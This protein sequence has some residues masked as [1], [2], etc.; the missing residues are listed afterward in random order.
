MSTSQRTG[1]RTPVV[2][3]TGFLGAGKSTLVNQLLRDP[4]MTN[5]ALIINEFGDISIDDDLIRHQ[6]ETVVE[7][8]GGCVCCAMQATLSETLATLDAAAHDGIDRVLIETTGLANVGPV[9]H[10]IAAD[11]DLQRSHE[12]YAVATVVSAANGSTTLDRHPE[13]V[14]QLAVA[15]LIVVTKTDL[16]EDP[17]DLLDRIECLNPTAD[18]AIAP[19][20]K[21]PA[22]TVLDA[23]HAGLSNLERRA[24]SGR[25]DGRHDAH[26]VT[27]S[28][29]RDTPFA[30]ADLTGFW[31]SVAAHAGA[32]L[33]RV[34]GFIAVEGHR[35]P[36]VIQGAQETMSRI[37]WLDDW[38]SDDRRSRIVF[39]GWDLDQQS[40]EDELF[41]SV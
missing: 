10:L 3:V 18:V 7:L 15:D 16:V 25:S 35:G 38:P 28:V 19:F 36:A 33:L 20:G 31:E 12:V 6:G 1:Q 22:T 26:I 32:N 27:V 5:T 11:E 41:P 9:I 30:Q 29:V 39:I 17:S 34:K 23:T 4:E 13:S 8:A 2:I 21:V 40:I 37:A 24:T 14:E